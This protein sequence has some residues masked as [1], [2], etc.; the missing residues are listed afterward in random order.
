ML[1]RALH[2][3]TARYICISAEATTQRKHLP[4]FACE[5]ECVSRHVCMHMCRTNKRRRARVNSERMRKCSFSE[6]GQKST[7]P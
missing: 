3:H 6:W 7:S 4:V 1:C 5:C 2:A